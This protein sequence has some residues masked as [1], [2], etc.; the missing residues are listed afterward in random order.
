M[1]EKIQI[2]FK[3]FLFL[4]FFW[5]LKTYLSL[6]LSYYKRVKINNKDKSEDFKFKIILKNIDIMIIDSI[7]DIT[8]ILYK[9]LDF[10]LKNQ[11]KYDSLFFLKNKIDNYLENI[12]VH[13]LKVFLFIFFKNTNFMII[14]TLFNSKY[15]FFNILKFSIY[16]FI[17]FFL[18]FIIF[19]FISIFNFIDGEISFQNVKSNYRTI[20]NKNYLIYFNERTFIILKC[21]FYSI[22]FGSHFSRTLIIEIQFFFLLLVIPW[23]IREF[24]YLFVKLIERKKLLRSDQSFLNIICIRLIRKDYTL[25]L[26]II[27]IHFNIIRAILFWIDMHNWKNDFKLLNKVKLNFLKENKSNN[28]EKEN[29]NYII[30]NFFNNYQILKKISNKHIKHLFYYC[31][32]FLFPFIFIFIITNPFKIFYLNDLLRSSTFS[33]KIKKL[34]NLFLMTFEDLLCIIMI[35]FLIFSF[36]NTYDIILLL[37]HFL[38]SKFGQKNESLYYFYYNN[39]FKK[40]VFYLFIK[41]IKSS[42]AFP[43]LFFNFIFIIRL[44][45]TFMRIKSYFNSKISRDFYLLKILLKYN[46]SKDLNLKSNKIIKDLFIFKLK[47]KLINKRKNSDCQVQVQKLEN[48]TNQMNDELIKKRNKSS[49][50]YSNMDFSKRK[51]ILLGTKY[52]YLTFNNLFEISK[53]LKPID[54]IQL[55]LTCVKMYLI[56]NLNQIWESQYNNYFINKI[57]KL[58]R[59][60]ILITISNSDNKLFKERCKFSSYYINKPYLELTNIMRDSYINFSTIIFEE[61]LETIWLLPHIILILMKIISYLFEFIRVYIF[62][63]FIYFIFNDNFYMKHIIFLF[64]SKNKINIPI[65][66]QKKRNNIYNDNLFKIK[67]DFL[68]Y[69]RYNFDISDFYINISSFEFLLN[70][71]NNML[72]I[73]IKGVI[74]VVDIIYII[75][76]IIIHLFFKFVITILSLISFNQRIKNKIFIKDCSFNYSK[77]NNSIKFEKIDE[78]QFDNELKFLNSISNIR[79][80]KSDDNLFKDRKKEKVNFSNIISKNKLPLSYKL[81]I[82]SKISNYIQ[83]ILSCLILMIILILLILPI[84]YTFK[85]KINEIMEIFL[86]NYFYERDYFL[87]TQ[88]FKFH[89]ILEILNIVFYNFDLN[90]IHNIFIIFFFNLISFYITYKTLFSLKK[91]FSS[92]GN[93]I[94]FDLLYS[95]ITPNISKVNLNIKNFVISFIKLILF[96]QTVFM[97]KL[98]KNYQFSKKIKFLLYLLVIFH[99]LFIFTPKFKIS[100]LRLLIV[101]L[102]FL[103]N[104]IIIIKMLFS[105]NIN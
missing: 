44:K 34:F 86:Y 37:Y 32:I 96:P 49:S 92:F 20:L 3:S 25:C 46:I 93:I 73:Q 47:S 9:P 101:I 58:E 53:Y 56:M 83:I 70:R 27:L 62:L 40:E 12:Y 36:I 97:I 82:N 84:V 76:Q 28:F 7:H 18:I 78:F 55:S 21:L 79:K 59:F 33:I 2:I 77:K 66:T 64:D 42:I 5:K 29:I 15:R 35:S 50:K 54:I 30:D 103:S 71:D 4:I 11:S 24:Y 19:R 68:N 43:L 99:P 98:I 13:F 102:Y 89:N 38:K 95:Y 8:Y 75:S 52:F 57:N 72:N 90:D 14:N 31:E 88:N 48:K 65:L 45:S 16:L 26:K 81:K 100:F 61:T 6:V 41:L 17:D 80:S 91:A 10:I 39:S 85:F 67:F 1:N 51:Q 22:D 23:R 87:I 69:F 74:V 63:I 94:L 60:D 105:T 104:I